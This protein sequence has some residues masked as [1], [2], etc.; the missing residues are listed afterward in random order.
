MSNGFD[1]GLVIDCPTRYL[2]DLQAK[3]AR[4]QN[5]QHA[6][7]TSNRLLVDDHD[8]RGRTERSHSPDG[9]SGRTAQSSGGGTRESSPGTDGPREAGNLTNPL[10]ETPSRFM[11]ASNGRTCR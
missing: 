1:L 11:A 4:L 10:T 7:S 8:D 5:A 9:P 3:V 6:P 2:S